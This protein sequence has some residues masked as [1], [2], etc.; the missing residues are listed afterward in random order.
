MQQRTCTYEDCTNVHRAKGYCTKHYFRWRK[1]GDP[2][3][4]KTTAH[5]WPDEIHQDGDCM[6]WAHNIDSHGYG[7]VTINSKQRL[8][9]RYAWE[10]ASGQ[11]SKGLLVD[12]ACHNRTCVNPRHLR[13]AT[14]QQNNSNRRGATKE[15]TTGVRNVYPSRN[16]FCVMIRK[17]GVLKTYGTYSTIEEASQ[18]AEETRAKLFGDFSGRG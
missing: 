1:H 9:H 18:V 14:K 4:V 13:V 16:K 3:I 8:A 12:H 10:Q 17:D 6:I 2:S 11:S 15:S 5:V 7:R